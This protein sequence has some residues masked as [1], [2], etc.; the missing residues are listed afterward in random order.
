MVQPWGAGGHGCSA[1]FGV[2]THAGP[3]GS[4]L[5]SPTAVHPCRWD[6]LI[7]TSLMYLVMVPRAQ[8]GSWAGQFW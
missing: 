1:H 7:K 8:A 2:A 6:L 5:C 4:H 3:R